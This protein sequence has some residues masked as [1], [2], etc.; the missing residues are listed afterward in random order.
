MKIISALMV[1]LL[2]GASAL[3]V[4][5]EPYFK[6]APMPFYPRLGRQARISGTVTLHF[7]VTEK[8][9]TTDVEATGAHQLLR[10]SAIQNVENWKYGWASPCEC[11]GK[12]QVVFVYSFGDWLNG[13]GPDSVVKWF[14]KNAVIRVEIQAGA[15]LI[16]TL[17]VR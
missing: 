6:S 9:D 10:D 12:R 1:F 15:D 5:R 8:G 3:G 4:D 16:N 14:G 11:R 13:N 2:L 7:T 17:R